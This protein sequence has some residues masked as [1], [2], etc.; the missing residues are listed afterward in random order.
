MQLIII[1]IK[2]NGL[3]L[4]EDRQTHTYKSFVDLRYDRLHTPKEMYLGYSYNH[5]VDNPYNN[6]H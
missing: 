3:S 4:P 2:H 6:E 5:T 1:I